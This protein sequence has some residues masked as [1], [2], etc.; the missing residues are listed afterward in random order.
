MTARLSGA[1]QARVPVPYLS[2]EQEAAEW[3]GRCALALVSMKYTEAPKQHR[4]GRITEQASSVPRDQ[5]S[6]ARS[7]LYQMLHCTTQRHC[8]LCWYAVVDLWQDSLLQYA[9]VHSLHVYGVEACSLSNSP[10]LHR[11]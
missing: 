4:Y 2:T 6:Y 9:C 7:T 3:L 11:A 5:A 10:G 1:L 8:A